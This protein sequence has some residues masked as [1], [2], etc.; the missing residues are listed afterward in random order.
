MNSKNVDLYLQKAIKQLTE[1][2]GCAKDGYG[3]AAGHFAYLAALNAAAALVHDRTG[4]P[5]PHEKKGTSHKSMNIQFAAVTRNEPRLPEEFHSILP[6]L[7]DLKRLADYELGEGADISATMALRAI[8]RVSRFLDCIRE[9]ITPEC[10]PHKH[11][12]PLP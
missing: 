5:D 10:S 11:H 6:Q 8:E 2:Q 12:T 4:K 3:N 9:L 7:Y 1:A